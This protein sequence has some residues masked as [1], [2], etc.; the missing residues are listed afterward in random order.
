LH[1]PLAGNTRL[2]TVQTSKPENGTAQRF[3]L[4]LLLA[5]FISGCSVLP[6]QQA[7]TYASGS[8][9]GISHLT[10]LSRL[11]ATLRQQLDPSHACSDLQTASAQEST[12]NSLLELQPTFK[13]LQ[14]DE[15]FLATSTLL[16]NSPDG[17]EESTLPTRF[18]H[19][20]AHYLEDADYPCRFPVYGGYFARRYQTRPDFSHC[21]ATVPFFL[22]DSRI[23]GQL[24]QLD[25]TR[26][27][28]IHLLYSIEGA[29][30]QSS[31]GHVAL[32]LIVCPATTSSDHECAINL[33]QQV[34]LGF[35]GRVDDLV[36]NP[37]KGMLGGYDAHLS[38]FTFREIYRNN[39]LF[40]D[41]GMYSLPLRLTPDNLQQMVR[42]L[43]E[44]HWSYRGNYRFFTNNCATLLQD[45]LAQMME[46]YQQDDQL[47]DGFLRPDTFFAAARK[48][49]LTD[50]SGLQD[51]ASAERNGYY[52]SPNKPYY[53]QALQALASKRQNMKSISL[54]NYLNAPGLQRRHWI[55]QDPL[56]LSTIN[57]DPYFLEAQ[58]LLEEYVLWHRW[59]ALNI[60][61]IKYLLDAATT[62]HLQQLHQKF[63]NDPD[64]RDFLHNCY[65]VPLERIGDR[66]PRANGLPDS[67]FL[68]WYQTSPTDCMNADRREQVR[69][70]I[71]LH[72]PENSDFRQQSNILVDD[73]QATLT[74]LTWLKAISRQ[75]LPTTTN[76]S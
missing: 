58:Q 36:T 13:A 42:E 73:I 65:E 55:E 23:G 9:A 37:A 44:I 74:N 49:P 16:D 22:I 15:R 14:P 33:Q 54:D 45:T 35:M 62:E 71:N 24:V 63:S 27:R 7:E 12:V 3:F 69:Q 52:F 4:A 10:R 56:L 67:D 57:Q 1:S 64:M 66:L 75:Q 32:R 17:V 59:R 46:S 47:A 26:I 53:H 34:V 19:E 31:F 28:A 68:A 30:L 5:V 8:C 72:I 40:D 6:R 29:A 70:V 51:L 61:T 21:S 2:L 41:R 43:S 25:P 39:A 38:A 50:A 11:P 60:L 76:P 18:A 20:L 48:S